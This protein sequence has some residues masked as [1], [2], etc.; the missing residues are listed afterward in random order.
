MRRRWL[1]PER[2]FTDQRSAQQMA[3]KKNMHS[4]QKQSA[5][6]LF[7]FPI[8]LASL[9]NRDWPLPP[10]LSIFYCFMQYIMLPWS[11]LPSVLHF[12]CLSLPPRVLLNLP[13]SIF[14]FLVSFN[15]PFLSL[16][17]ALVSLASC[18]PF[19]T[20]R[21]K[22]FCFLLQCNKKG[23]A[24]YATFCPLGGLCFFVFPS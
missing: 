21:W 10:S 17:L 8:L 7:L 18:S 15:S 19:L 11:K 24:V 1:N 5:M 9:L 13:I 6:L 22:N 23:C 20:F 12:Y 2:V 3:L 16:S 4:R 14:C